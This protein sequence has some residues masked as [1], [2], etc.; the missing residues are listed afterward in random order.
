MRPTHHVPPP[1]PSAEMTAFI[2]ERDRLLEPK[3]GQAAIDLAVELVRLMELLAVHGSTGIEGDVD[4]RARQVHQLV[5]R[6]RSAT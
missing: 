1:P 6:I 5:G 4:R 3:S 2:E